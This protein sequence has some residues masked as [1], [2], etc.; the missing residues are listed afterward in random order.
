MTLAERKVSFLPMNPPRGNQH[1]A[2][3]QQQCDLPDLYR[4]LK[5]TATIILAFLGSYVDPQESILTFITELRGALNLHP[6]T[7][8]Q[9]KPLAQR[10]AG[11]DCVREKYEILRDELHR[12]LRDA[13]GN[14]V[15]PR[16]N[17]ELI[18]AFRMV[19]AA[20]NGV[21]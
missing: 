1:S 18:E 6:H 2:E 21:N 17:D 16:D 14:T 12:T 4:D 10:E 13:S 19:I 5:G 11:D 7:T 9:N 8:L 15:R 3:P 20:R